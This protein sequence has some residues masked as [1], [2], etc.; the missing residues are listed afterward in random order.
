MAGL[1]FSSNRFDHPSSLVNRLGDAAVE[2]DTYRQ[3]ELW[4]RH[5]PSARWQWTF[6]LPYRQHLRQTSE[7]TPTLNGL[8]DAS[9]QVNRRIWISSDTSKVRQSFWFGLGLQLPTGP[10]M[11]RMPNL[12]QWPQAFQTGSGSYALNLMVFNSWVK[13]NWGWS[14]QGSARISSTNE[15]D[16]RRGDF[17]QLQWSGWWNKTI[18]RT[19]QLA[20]QLGFSA[21]YWAKDL[22]YGKIQPLSDGQKLMAWIG[23]DLR[24]QRYLF[25]AQ[26]SQPLIQQVYNSGPTTT[27]RLE[28][29]LGVML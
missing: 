20:P 26:L 21:E 1:R 22:E 14:A 8:G 24:Y 3:F 2:Y 6:S 25:R 28:L 4:Y 27:L 12:T 16:Y 23:T 7:E 15:L 29:G 10:F 13:G 18:F 11:Q 17:Y 5:M 9:A 19:I